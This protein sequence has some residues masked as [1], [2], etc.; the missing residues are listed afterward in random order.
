MLTPVCTSAA[1]LRA[2]LRK[3]RAHIDF[4]VTKKNLGCFATHEKNSA[5]SHI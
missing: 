3:V 5:H 1:D 4:Y 2:I